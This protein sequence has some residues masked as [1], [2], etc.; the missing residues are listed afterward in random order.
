M[1]VIEPYAQQLPGHASSPCYPFAGFVINLNVS[2]KVHR[3]A[4]DHLICLVLPVG[5][6]IGGEL[7][8]VEP[9]LVLPLR[10]GDMTI[11][12]SQDISHFNLTYQGARA[13]LVCHTDREGLK[14]VEDRFKWRGNDYFDDEED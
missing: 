6:F 2:T 12:P 11:F 7:C 1:G 8:L 13:S 10:S 3:D 4:K 9:G 5:N 14:W